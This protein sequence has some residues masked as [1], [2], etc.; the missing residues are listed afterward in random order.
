MNNTITKAKV[1]REVDYILQN[2]PYEIM[3]KVPSDFKKSIVDNMDI[4]YIPELLDKS[5]PL[6]EQK[7]S[8]ET[9]KILALIYRNYIV[10]EEI[11]MAIKDQ[12]KKVKNI[13]VLAMRALNLVELNI[14]SMDGKSFFKADAC[15][16]GAK[17]QMDCP[18]R[19]NVNYQFQ[20]SYQ[21]H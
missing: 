17:F 14:S 7:I 20:V 19:R 16:T 12:F 13:E 11:E 6:D 3:N 4:N 10:S 21:Y 15:I 8:E 2:L 9:K 1:L 18:M 5:K